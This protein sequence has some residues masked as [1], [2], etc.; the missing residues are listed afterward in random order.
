MTTATALWLAEREGQGVI[1]VTGT[2]GKSSTAALTAHLARAAGR[3]AH[4]AGNIGIPALDLL[5]R[6]PRIWRYSSCRATRW[7][8]SS[9]APRSW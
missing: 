5:E 4:L 8:I 3:T 6:A 9:V 1:G 2:K 7:P